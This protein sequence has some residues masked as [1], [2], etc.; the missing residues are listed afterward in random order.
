MKINPLNNPKIN[1]YKPQIQQQQQQ[2]QSKNQATDQVEIS[3]EAKQLQQSN[4]I[5]EARQKKVE[6]LKREVQNGT[7]QLDP[8]QTAEKMVEFWNGR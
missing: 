3:K 8:K 1:A 4:P 5:V 6:S 2:T 7:Y